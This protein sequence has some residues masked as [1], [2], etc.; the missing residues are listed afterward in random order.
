MNS[1][2]FRITVN[3]ILHFFPLFPRTLTPFPGRFHGTPSNR[4]A[5]LLYACVQVRS[6]ERPQRDTHA[7]EI[8]EIFEFLTFAEF[9]RLFFSCVLLENQEKMFQIIFTKLSTL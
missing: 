1:R 9:F 6:K 5:N 3:S 8:E 7:A 2:T 4:P